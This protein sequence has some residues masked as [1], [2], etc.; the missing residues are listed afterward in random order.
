MMDR[1]KRFLTLLDLQKDL[2]FRDYGDLGLTNL[3]ALQREVNAEIRRMEQEGRERK[4]A[5][6][7]GQ[8]VPS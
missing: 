1:M 2:K 8:A 7:A 5:T 4:A 6:P 3:I